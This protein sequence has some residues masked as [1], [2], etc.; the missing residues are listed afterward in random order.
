[1]NGK[2]IDV[3]WHTV[4]ALALAAVLAGYP[5]LLAGGNT[6]PAVVLFFMSTISF[7]TLLDHSMSPAVNKTVAWPQASLPRDLRKLVV[8]LGATAIAMLLIT[9]A[10]YNRARIGIDAG[11]L[12]WLTLGYNQF[13][14]G[15]VGFRLNV[16]R[17]VRGYSGNT[18]TRAHR[19]MRWALSLVHLAFIGFVW[20]QMGSVGF[21]IIGFATLVGID[22][23]LCLGLG[24]PIGL[25][26]SKQI[27]ARIKRERAEA[28]RMEEPAPM[29]QARST[30]PQRLQ[31][32][33]EMV[34]ELRAEDEEYSA[35]GESQ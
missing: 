5:L 21:T 1:M 18:Q 3:G 33:D 12:V 17:S 7:W 11:L 6:L 2:L 4:R 27:A 20:Q 35:W 30:R 19:L 8:L 10:T 16:L 24:W 26:I 25:L 13:L 29:P 31:S 28:A 23:L 34:E 15:H 14:L 32:I 22:A 9:L